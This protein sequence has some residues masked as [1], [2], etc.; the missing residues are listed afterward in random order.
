MLAEERRFRIREILGVQRTVSASQLTE[1][2]EVT[3]ATIRRDLEELEQEGVLIRSH[4]GAVSRTSSTNFQL[5]YEVLLRTNRK[6]KEA[7]ARA[8]E[9]LILDGETV[10]LEASSTVYELARI[11]SR[12]SRLTIV[13]NS[14]PVLALLQSSPAITVMAT[15]GDLVRD[16]FFLGGTWAERVISEIR[17][18]KAIMGVTAIDIEY[19]ISAARHVES[20][21][22]K[23]LVKAARTR[24]A[25]ADHTKFG[26]QSFAYVGPVSDLNILVTDDGIEAAQ[27]ESLRQL[28]IETI[29]AGADPERIMHSE[30]NAKRAKVKASR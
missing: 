13:T 3:A 12:R 23:R 2:L 11:L 18:D 8:A 4:G 10:F 6:E 20:E 16:S 19:G 30:R 21:I 17:L 28:G 26:K 7:I 9:H 27:L 5:S 29:V 25:L 24:I 22:K 1:M 14:P 15:G